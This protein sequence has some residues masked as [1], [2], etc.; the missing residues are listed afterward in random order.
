MTLARASAVWPPFAAL[1][2]AALWP[3]SAHAVNPVA[4]PA[5]LAMA[6]GALVIADRPEWGI[7][8]VL[9]LAPLTNLEI[10]E[11]KPLHLILPAL[12]GGVLLYAT[13]VTRSRLAPAGHSGVAAAVIFFSVAALTSALFAIDP[14]ASVTRL[15]VVLTA[16]TLFFA[17]TQLAD[18]R[19]RLEVVLYGVLLGLLVAAVHGISQ[20][21]LNAFGPSGGVLISGEVINR[22]QGSFGHPN[23]YAGYLAILMPLAAAV[24]LTREASPR[25][26]AVGAATFLLAVQPLIF[27]FTRGAIVAIVAGSLLWLAVV[28]PRS[29][30][31]VAAVIAVLG[32]SFAPAALRER[33]QIDE[34]GGD[35]GLRMDIWQSAL[36]IYERSPVVGVGLN[37]FEIAYASLP[38][39]I[40]AGSQRRLLHQS[41]LLVPPHANNL[42]LNIL[43]EQGLI[44]MG[45]FLAL[46]GTGVALARRLTKVR[47]P[48][49]RAVGIGL[50]CGLMV[51]ALHSLLEITLFG[52]IALPLF[53]MLGVDCGYLALSRERAK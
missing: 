28:R 43:A 5:M 30:I 26:R 17:V 32:V 10:D 25:L 19:R 8:V 44:G 3:L 20:Q 22:V 46:L 53:A 11:S 40:S 41:Q 7:A 38:S 9:G 14:G 1:V 29:V 34:A 12:A 31:I 21:V 15:F 6:A 48:V 13:L 36:D 47:D 27:S 24:A 35:I 50:G 4:L 49:G 18:E 45:A 37:N 52:E 39:T 51:M 2:L 42:S 16:A 23:T 33:L